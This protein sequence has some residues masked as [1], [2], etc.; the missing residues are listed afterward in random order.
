MMSLSP[1]SAY[2]LFETIR[3]QD[4]I[5]LH[6]EYHAERINRSHRE[7]LKTT[8]RISADALRA[9]I[10]V[11][12]PLRAGRTRIRIAYGMVFGEP[13]YFSYTPR[14]ISRLV[15]IDAPEIHYPHKYSDRRALDALKIRCAGDEE[16]LICSDGLIRET[17]FS[18][19][20]LSDGNEFI[21]PAAPLLPGT[22]I[23]R[24]IREGIVTAVPLTPDDLRRYREA[25][26]VNAMLDPGDLIIPVTKATIRQD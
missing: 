15:L 11:P 12:E 17:C 23:A 8:E 4:G 7:V 2:P 9:M 21:T 16:P 26:C 19:I 5:P 3:A 13:E 25:H 14:R 1:R 22:A 20:V 18:S 24:L 6:L 10:H